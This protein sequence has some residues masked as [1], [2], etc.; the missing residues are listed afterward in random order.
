MASS[1]NI[2]PDLRSFLFVKK[3]INIYINKTIFYCR[4]KIVLLN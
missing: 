1:D 3:N 4:I 2:A